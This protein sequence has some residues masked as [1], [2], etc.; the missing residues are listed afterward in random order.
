M[1]QC[2]VSWMI[3]IPVKLRVLFIYTDGFVCLISDEWIT[4]F[5]SLVLVVTI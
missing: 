4:F 1:C 2:L 5:C 3:V